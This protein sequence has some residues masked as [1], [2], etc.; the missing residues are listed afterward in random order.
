MDFSLFSKLAQIPSAPGREELLAE[1]IISEIKPYCDEIRVDRMGNVIA[2]KKGKGGGSRVM[3]AAH[4]DEVSLKVRYIDDKG[5]IYFT[6]TGGIDARTLLSQRVAIVT[7]EH[8]LIPG[9]IG[10]K[11]AHYLT[12]AEKTQGVD[13]ASLCIDTGYGVREVLDMVAIGDPV[14]LD[15]TPRELGGDLFTSKAIDDRAGVYILLEV[16]KN[17][18]KSHRNDIYF[19]FSVQEEYGLIGAEAATA[20]IRPEVALAV[21]TT[22]AL[23]TPGMRPQDYVVSLG[24]GIGITLADSSTIADRALSKHLIKICE[25]NN[26]A[27]Q[28]RV[29]ARGSNDAKVMQRAGGA[30]RAAALSV[31]VRYI[32]SNVETASK[33]DI[34]AA[35]NLVLNFLSGDFEG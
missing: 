19:V 30:A 26:I 31:P 5:F 34:D 10:A 12:A 14:V 33:K 18:P 11:A 28:L 22:G 3:A 35:Y 6:L 7:E 27:Y 15:R 13:A 24:K 20:D 9:V 21:D 23:D 2:L 25:D 4:M 29:A 17:M 8:G 32:H 16:I 1:E